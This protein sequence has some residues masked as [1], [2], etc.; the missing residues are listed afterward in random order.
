M[1]SLIIFCGIGVLIVVVIFVLACCN[2]FKWYY[3]LSFVG[4]TVGVAFG[5][6]LVALLLTSPIGCFAPQE[7]KLETT[8][9]M[10]NLADNYGIQG[11]L[12]FGTGSINSVPYYDYYYQTPDSVLFR[13]R[14]PAEGVP[15]IEEDRQDG[16]V[17]VY[18]YGPKN[19]QFVH[20]W[21]AG[22]FIGAFPEENCSVHSYR[23]ELRVP[24]GT[25]KRNGF[26][27]ALD[28]Q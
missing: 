15:V 9:H 18:H 27:G 26:L 12:F 10:V 2:G 5:A 7:W 20:N 17:L 13:E 28:L 24:K 1:I 22:H 19:P 25:I 3:P 16:V 8:Q 6:S 21:S 4:G 14:I 23:Y 11:Y